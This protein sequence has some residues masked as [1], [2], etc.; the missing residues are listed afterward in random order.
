MLNDNFRE[1]CDRIDYWWVRNRSSRE[2]RE[3]NVY[4][5]AQPYRDP[6]K[7]NNPPQWQKDMARWVNKRELFEKLSFKDYEPRKGFKCEEYFY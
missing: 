2:K 4:P 5:Y 6:I 7:K 1:C 3:P